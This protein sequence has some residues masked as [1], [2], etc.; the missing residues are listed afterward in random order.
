MNMIII[1]KIK[2]DRDTITVYSDGNIYDLSRHSNDWGSNHIG[3]YALAAKS[4][5]S[6]ISSGRTNV[7]KRACSFLLQ[8][9]GSESRPFVLTLINLRVEMDTPIFGKGIK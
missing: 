8:M 4:L 2:S 7:P 6:Y 5:L 1:G 3:G 9:D